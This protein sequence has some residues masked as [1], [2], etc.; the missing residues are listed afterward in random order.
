MLG[1]QEALW[2]QLAGRYRGRSVIWAYDLLNEPAVLWD[3]P[4]MR[5]KWN[6]WLDATYKTPDALAAAWGLPAESVRLGSV[7]PP[8]PKDD[9]GSKALLDY[10]HFR[11]SIA[12]AWTRRQVAA[13]RKADPEALVT[14][15]L[16]QWSVPLNLGGASQYAAFRPERQA[17]LLDFSEVHF[18][19]FDA[20]AY[21]YQGPEAER[22]HLA[23]LKA[24]V[25]AVARAGKPVVLAE[26]GW[27]GGGK[28]TLGPGWIDATEEDQ[29]RWCRK[30]VESTAG[31]AVGWLNWG[32]YDHPQ[33]RD[34][35]QFTGFWTTDGRPK[36]WAGTFAELATG[37]RATPPRFRVP[38]GPPLDWDACLV[39]AP[40]R[41]T[42]RRRLIETR[43]GE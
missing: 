8:A 18:Y 5:S 24:V 29:A 13:I 22:R 9:P 3:S 6:V 41:A 4:A 34:V 14:V 21:H 35:T 40:A 12:D 42:A 28:P 19:P 16:I 25:D 39:G 15:G 31:S 38:T 37:F 32:L 30:A 7:P 27:Y 26:F 36:A 43:P 33:A 1:A 20:G 11:E 23:Y 10:Q 2:T 17:P